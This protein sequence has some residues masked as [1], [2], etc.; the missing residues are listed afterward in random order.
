MITT[1]ETI[2]PAREASVS[3]K[4]VIVCDFCETLLTYKQNCLL[5]ERDLCVKH[6]YDDPNDDSDY[7]DL[8]CAICYYMKFTTFAKQYAKVKD[9]YKESLKKLDM[10][11]KWKSQGL[12][13]GEWYKKQQ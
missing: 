13:V 7:A 6:S 3:R 5:C 9:N 4:D 11:I 2:V 8:Y 12:T 10:K 1:K